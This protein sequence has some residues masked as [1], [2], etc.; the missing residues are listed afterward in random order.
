MRAWFALPVLALVAC[1]STP[2]PVVLDPEAHGRLTVDGF[3][4]AS[5]AVATRL[6][7]AA[8][9]VVFPDV[10]DSGATCAHAGTLF[11]P[12]ARPRAATLTCAV[13]P[14][15]PAGAAYHMLVVLADPADVERLVQGALELGDAPRLTPHDDHGPPPDSETVWVVTSQRGSLLFDAWPALQRI[16]LVDPE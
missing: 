6:E 5:A 10:E 12:G 4:E 15:A 7:T 3:R 2:E 1:A 16:T 9:W 11:R 8:A 14:T 13:R